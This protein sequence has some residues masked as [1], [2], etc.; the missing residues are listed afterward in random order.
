[1]SCPVKKKSEKELNKEIEA[2]QVEAWIMRGVVPRVVEEA[3][4]KNGGIE[5]K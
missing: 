2:N 5:A 4:K 3:R 1:M